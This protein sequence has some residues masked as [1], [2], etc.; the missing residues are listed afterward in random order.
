VKSTLSLALAA[1]LATS[2]VPGSAEALH[3]VP[4]PLAGVAARALAQ[5]PVQRR[6]QSPADGAWSRLRHLKPGTDIVV[7]TRTAPA[8]T[9][10]FVA[11]T[12][13]A[14]AVVDA[15]NPALPPE[16]RRFL[17]HVVADYPA[18]FAS[19]Q[20]GTL[21]R[22]GARIGPDG[23]FLGNRRLAGREEIVQHLERADVVDV[24]AGEA[25]DWPSIRRLTPGTS[26]VI[27]LANGTP[28]TGRLLIASDTSL[29]VLDVTDPLLPVDVREALEDLA[30]HHA[31]ELGGG[32]RQASFVNGEVRIAADGVF[33][34]TRKI[35]ERS[36]VVRSVQRLDVV[37]VVAP[38]PNPHV[39]LWIGVGAALA[40]VLIAYVSIS[41]LK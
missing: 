33:V 38:R 34:G 4:N 18:Y 7:T 31:G 41:Q 35:A 32:R 11:A 28:L 30:V 21:T 29:T 23:L 25:L 5:R 10:L 8:A 16:A 27:S 15:R 22:D 9:R 19:S 36:D 26:V 37:E 3:P 39:G 24:H 2:P 12:D 17:L 20:P 6:S 14:L 1:A 40:A 13:D